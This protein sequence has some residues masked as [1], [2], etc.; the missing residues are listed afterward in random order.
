MIQLETEAR[1]RYCPHVAGTCLGAGC[2]AWAPR[3]EPMVDEDIAWPVDIAKPVLEPARDGG[4]FQPDDTRE[5]AIRFRIAA[6]EALRPLLGAKPD[7][8]FVGRAIPRDAAL[9]TVRLKKL[10]PTVR[11]SCSLMERRA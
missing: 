6:E 7:G 5:R 4:F 8:W 9:E 10:P 3:Q 11:G 1:T 2:M